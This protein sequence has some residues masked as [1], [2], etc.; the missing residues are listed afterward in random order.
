[1]GIMGVIGIIG[2][3]SVICI[4]GIIIKKVARQKSDNLICESVDKMWNFKACEIRESGAYYAYVSISRRSVTPKL[5][6]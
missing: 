1:M 6:F 2:I 3:I 4:I 5:P